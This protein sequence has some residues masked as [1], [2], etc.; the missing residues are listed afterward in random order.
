[1]TIGGK[2]FIPLGLSPIIKLPM[3]WHMTSHTC[4]CSNI[5]GAQKAK[6]T[7]RRGY[8][9]GGEIGDEYSQDT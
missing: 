1:M 3:F 6:K 8:E 4:V 7:K 9:G 5:N 2:K